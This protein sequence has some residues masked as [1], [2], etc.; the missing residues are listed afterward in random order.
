MK[1]NIAINYPGDGL[2]SFNHETNSDYDE[3]LEDVFGMFNRG[4]GS[5]SKLFADSRMRSLSVND[6]V[7]VNGQWY[8]CQGHGW[9][10]VTDEYV[11]EL[12]KSVVSHPMFSVNGAWWCLSDIMAKRSI[13]YGNGD[14]EWLIDSPGVPKR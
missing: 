12:E 11:D 6:F 1:Y 14:K 5:E 9:K 10:K 4:S 13:E 7:S 8:Q 2:I 3:V